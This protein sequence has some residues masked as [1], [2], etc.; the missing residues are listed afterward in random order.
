MEGKRVLITG[1]AGYIGNIL[2]KHLLEKEYKV[3]CL[4]NFLYN[5]KNTQLIHINNPNYN[6]V[7]GD[8]R[9]EKTLEKLVSE[10]DI[11][12]PL[13][14]LVGMPLCERKPEEAKQINYEA[15]GMLNRIRSKNQKIIFPNT[16]S[17]YGTKTGETFCTEETPLNPISVYG[18]T[19]CDAE[20][21][22]LDSGKPSIVLR[23]ATLFG[24]SPR[25]RTDLMVNDFTLKAMRDKSIVIYEGDFKRNFIYIGDVAKCFEYCISNFDSMKNQIYNLGLNEANISKIELAKKIKSYLPKFE[26]INKEIGEDPDKRDYIV[27]NEKILKKGFKPTVGLDQGIKELIK[28]YEII[29]TSNDYGN[30]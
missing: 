5:Q 2:S 30:A 29:L 17:G 7:Y 12:I 25:M 6:F 20:K 14:A 27:S 24:V 23:L 26:I 28:A 19:K 21:S 4:D 10:N 16:N 13:A 22:I 3:T 1:G 15:I 9:N 18:K 11:I 8:T